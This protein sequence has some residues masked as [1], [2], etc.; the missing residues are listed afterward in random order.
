MP[1]LDLEQDIAEEFSDIRLDR[2]ELKR[3]AGAGIYVIGRRDCSDPRLQER[4][5][6]W[7]AS[8]PRCRFCDSIIK[9][10][11]SMNCKLPDYC[12]KRCADTAYFFRTKEVIIALG[13]CAQRCGN[14]AERDKSCCRSCLDKKAK[15]EAD[16]RKKRR[17]A[18][19]C[20]RCGEPSFDYRC[21]KCAEIEYSARRKYESKA[22]ARVATNAAVKARQAAKSPEERQEW[23]RRA[24]EIF[25]QK[26]TPEQRSAM[27]K[28]RARKWR[29]KK[30]Q[31]GE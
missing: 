28:E 18:G 26:T 20:R 16:K 17:S 5:R 8:K 12:G 22:A 21:A 19:L 14:K 6:T 2:R 23:S 9:S 1:W 29:A 7:L 10:L 15:R 24:N 30:L 4:R 25:M 3:D 31:D 11:S 27:M 13:L